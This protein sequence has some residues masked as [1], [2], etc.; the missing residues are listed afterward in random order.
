[1]PP[2]RSDA[3]RNQDLDAL[4]A[5]AHGTKSGGLDGA[6]IRHAAL[7]LLGD[8]ACNDVGIEFRSLDL[9]DVDLDFL[10]GELHQ[11]FLQLVDFLAALADDHARTSRE[12][13]DS[14]IFQGTF[15]GDL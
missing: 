1:M 2:R 13:G 4:G 3:T 15:D 11:F 9:V 10:A 14:D 5:H 7:N 6:A 12:D 8:G